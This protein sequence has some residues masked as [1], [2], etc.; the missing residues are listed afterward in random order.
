MNYVLV[1]QSAPYSSAALSALKFAQALAASQYEIS[2]I[3]FYGDAVA[4]VN[5]LQCPPQDELN[6]LQ[7]WVELLDQSHLRATVCI[8]AALRRGV[9]DENEAKRYNKIASNLRPPFLLA[10]LGELVEACSSAE[11]VV[12]FK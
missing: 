6:L 4:M 1:I 8:A 12:T 10:G 5:D 7:S 3:F 11:R 9:L 2:Q